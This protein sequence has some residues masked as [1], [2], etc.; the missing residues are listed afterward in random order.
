ML[1]RI[2]RGA[3]WKF[4]LLRLVLA[5]LAGAARDVGVA[6]GLEEDWL[7]AGVGAFVPPIELDDALQ[8][9]ASHVYGG[10]LRVTVASRLGLARLKFFAAVDEGIGSVHE[11][12]LRAMRLSEEEGQQVLDWYRER[13]AGREDPGLAGTVFRLWGGG[14]G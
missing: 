6:L 3:A 1:L 8:N 9:A 14:H 4:R 10:A 5:Q 7:N 13:F 2:L 11:D 12:D